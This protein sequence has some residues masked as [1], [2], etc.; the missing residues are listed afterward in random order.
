MVSKYTVDYH[1]SRSQ[2]ISTIRSHISMDSW[3]IYLSKSSSNFFFNLYIP[4]WL[5]KYF[6]CI[7]LRLLQIHFWVKKL[8]L[9]IFA[10]AS[11]QNSPLGFYHYPSGRQ[12]LR[13]PPKQ[14]F[15]KIFFPEAKERER[16]ME[17]KKLPKLT[18]LRYR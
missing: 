2:L 12:K 11:K 8:N 3:G 4:S 16:L 10:H 6:K 5:R 18:K 14:I 17:L 15:L 9:F 13:I 7:V 1:P